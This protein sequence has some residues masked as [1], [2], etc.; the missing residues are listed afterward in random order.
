ML[1]LS[2][3]LGT[4]ILTLLGTLC[5]ALTLGLR[6]QGVMLGLLILP[7][8]TPILIFGV[9]IVQQTEA[10]LPANAAIAF[11]ASLLVLAITTLPWTIAATLRV[12]L[13]E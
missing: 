9:S 3:L 4:P 12:A 6:Q 13:D 5:V 10:G 8:A 11:L 1:C 2:L 7:L